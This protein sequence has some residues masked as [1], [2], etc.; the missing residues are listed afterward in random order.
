MDISKRK[1]DVS[2]LLQLMERLRNKENGCPWDIEQDFTTIKPH[3]IEEA[4]EVADAIERNDMNDLKD[5]LGDLLFQVIFHAQ[6]ASE[7]GLFNFDDIVDHVT[8][9]MIFRHPHVFGDKKHD[10][11]SSD[12]VKNKIWEEQKAKEKLKKQGGDNQ[13][14][15][16]G[17]TRALPSLLFAQ[18]LQKSARKAG[19]KYPNINAVTDKLN[20]ELQELDEALS[21]NDP[22]HIEEEYGDILFITALIG[23]HID[24]NAE[25][26]LRLAC[27]KF[28]DRF[29]AMEDIMKEDNLPLDKATADDFERSWVKAKKRSSA[30]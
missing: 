4:Y 10:G 5:E 6:M 14:V 11:H 7:E 30:I 27:L 23:R 17:I 25:E 13:Y 15:L 9:K 18:K 16:D 3:T 26:A 21:G 8:K 12:D 19:F 24:V 20:E 1:Y 28:I 22:K 2:D 29:S